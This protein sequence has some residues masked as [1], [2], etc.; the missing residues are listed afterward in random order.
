[1]GFEIFSNPP[2][3][4]YFWNPAE[5]TAPKAEWDGKAPKD[6]ALYAEDIKISLFQIE[7]DI[8]IVSLDLLL[9][10]RGLRDR[11]FRNPALL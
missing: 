3:P 4:F 2:I 1:M 10:G 9:R 7:K 11:R 8:S 5:K 6:P